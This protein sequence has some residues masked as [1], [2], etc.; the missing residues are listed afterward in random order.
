MEHQVCVTLLWSSPG[1][2]MWGM[3]AQSGVEPRCLMDFWALRCLEEIAEAAAAGTAPPGHASDEAMADTVMDFLFA[4]QDASTASLVW[5]TAV[6][7]ERPDV[8]SK[9]H[10]SQCMPSDHHDVTALLSSLM[11]TLMLEVS[12]VFAR[13]LS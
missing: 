7:A 6:L 3:V 5:L 1:V 8:L 12:K 9:V 2:N 11:C 4:S 10:R 13:W